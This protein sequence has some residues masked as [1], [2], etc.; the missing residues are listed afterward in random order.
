MFFRHSILNCTLFGQLLEFRLTTI[1]LASFGIT[2]SISPV[3]EKKSLELKITKEKN[4]QSE[5]EKDLKIVL[6]IEVY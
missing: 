1:D 3:L 4:S 6:K 5:N 2:V